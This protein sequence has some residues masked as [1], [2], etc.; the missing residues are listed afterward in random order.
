MGFGA[1][2]ITVE[3]IKKELLEEVISEIFTLVLTINGIKT[4]GKTLMC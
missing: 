1:N 3:V 4:H 2:I